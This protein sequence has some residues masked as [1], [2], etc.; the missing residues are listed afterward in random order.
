MYFLQVQLSDQNGCSKHPAV[1][2]NFFSHD[3]QLRSGIRAKKVL[4]ARLSAWSFPTSSHVLISCR[5][6]SCEGACPG[7]PAACA[8]PPSSRAHSGFELASGENVIKNDTAAPGDDRLANDA[9]DDGFSADNDRVALDDAVVAY[10]VD[11]S[12]GATGLFS[13]GR[14]CPPQ[15]RAKAGRSDALSQPEMITAETPRLLSPDP[16]P[17]PPAADSGQLT[18][19]TGVVVNSAATNNGRKCVAM[20]VFV[21]LIS[22]LLTALGVM[23]FVVGFLMWKLR[24]RDRRASV[25]RIEKRGCPF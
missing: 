17:P 12:N 20:D 16:V 14:P 13:N 10:K 9:V 15:Q 8:H 23:T 25:V 1:W 18:S 21:G 4:L 7:G 22:S 6:R 5:A 11:R 19:R 3:I 24:E 2:S